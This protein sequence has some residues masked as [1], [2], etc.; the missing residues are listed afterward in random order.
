MARVTD[1]IISKLDTIDKGQAA[2]NERLS[3]MEGRFDAV[4]GIISTNKE[5]TDKAIDSLRGRS[6]RWDFITG[7][8]AVAAGVLGIAWKQQ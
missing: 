4:Y 5:D 3:R 2:I 7:I 6:E 8:I 1:L